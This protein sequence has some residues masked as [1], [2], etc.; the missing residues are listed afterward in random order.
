[1]SSKKWF[2]QE[3]S[4]LAGEQTR[5]MHQ[6]QFS[7]FTILTLRVELSQVFFFNSSRMDDDHDDRDL[8]PVPTSRGMER[9]I[10]IQNMSE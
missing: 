10:Q 3:N 2:R 9:Q 4:P 7:T 5:T 8:P 1:M 6:H